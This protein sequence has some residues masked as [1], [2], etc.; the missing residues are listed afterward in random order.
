MIEHLSL[1]Y[2]DRI[3]EAASDAPLARPGPTRSGFD[4]SWADK[5]ADFPIEVNM[6]FKRAPGQALI[7]DP[8]E[9]HRL[10]N[11]LGEVL[12]GELYQK[13]YRT[14]TVDEIVA[15][16]REHAHVAK[17]EGAKP[18]FG[19]SLVRYPS[20]ED[21]DEALALEAC[22][23]TPVSLKTTKLGYAAMLA[24]PS[25]GT[26]GDE[27]ALQGMG[28][29]SIQAVAWEILEHNRRLPPSALWLLIPRQAPD[30]ERIQFPSWDTGGLLR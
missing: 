29:G 17:R 18:V 1:S 12:G 30:V 13:V 26:G 8:E 16:E 24:Y 9:F 6:D 10:I 23:T 21:A 28:Y 20:T 14:M 2:R 7:A 27:L 11:T 4:P 5:P 15:H 19:L 3:E 22:F 25:M